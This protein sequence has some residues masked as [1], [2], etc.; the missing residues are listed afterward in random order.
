MTSVL[1]F[2]GQTIAEM[3]YWALMEFERWCIRELTRRDRDV[4][5]DLVPYEVWL[6]QMEALPLVRE[7]IARR[8][9]PPP[10]ER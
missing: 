6:W 1:T 7:E 8:S 2:H 10:M 5:A 9:V 4:V 3:S